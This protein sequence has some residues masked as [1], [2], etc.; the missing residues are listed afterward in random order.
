MSD[1]VSGPTEAEVPEKQEPEGRPERR[2]YVVLAVIMMICTVFCCLFS[3]QQVKS[4]NSKI[5][6]LIGSSVTTPVKE[7]ADPKKAP[8]QEVL[9]QKYIKTYKF[10]K[11]INCF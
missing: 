4:E 7:P 5:C 9:Y 3:I 6:S 1:D 11:S 2:A 8:N 10:A